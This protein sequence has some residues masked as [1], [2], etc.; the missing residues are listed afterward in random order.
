[1]P[2]GTFLLIPRIHSPADHYKG[3]AF[4]LMEIGYCPRRRSLF[5]NLVLEMVSLFNILFDRNVQNSMLT[6]CVVPVIAVFTKWDGQIIKSYGKLRGPPNNM[7]I[8]RAR[9]GAAR[10]AEDEFNQHYLP[11]I[12]APA[13]PYPP[14]S[15]VL[16]GSEWCFVPDNVLSSK[17]FESDMHKPE[18]R[19]EELSTKTAAALGNNELQK[20]FVSVQLNNIQLCVE[21]ALK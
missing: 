12:S 1:M 13:V 21:Y 18:T 9:Q 4:R 6:L 2:F 17:S 16:I 20:L 7:S 8:S 5:F 10:H 3:I 11:V 15:F 19:C 14:A